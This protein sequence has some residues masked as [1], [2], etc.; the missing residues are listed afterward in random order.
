MYVNCLSVAIAVWLNT[1]RRSQ[2]Y[3]A[4]AVSFSPNI[5]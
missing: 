2:R 1:S 5:I 4:V 3:I